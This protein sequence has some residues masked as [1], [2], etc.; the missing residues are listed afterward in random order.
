MLVVCT[1][2]SAILPRVTT[3][4]AL[5]ELLATA[6]A[7]NHSA[8]AQAAAS[9]DHVEEHVGAGARQWRLLTSFL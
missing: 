4:T 5:K 7:R 9:V 2:Q 1:L 6:L 8:A 3:A